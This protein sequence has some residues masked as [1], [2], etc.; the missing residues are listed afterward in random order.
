MMERSNPSGPLERKQKKRKDSDEEKVQRSVSDAIIRLT[1]CSPTTVAPDGE[2]ST[3]TSCTARAQ[4]ITSESIKAAPT[5]LPDWPD[6]SD[7]GL[8]KYVLLC[9]TCRK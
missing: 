5:D 6:L 2:T 8:G 4:P 1:P 9:I 3:S 7:M